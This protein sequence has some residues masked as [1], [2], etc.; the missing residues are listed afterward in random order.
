MVALYPE[1]SLSYSFDLNSI[2]LTLL[3]SNVVQPK[4]TPTSVVA[5]VAPY[6]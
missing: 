6:L 2:L 1:Y 4:M 3:C 5:D